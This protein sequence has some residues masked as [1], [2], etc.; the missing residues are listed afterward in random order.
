MHLSFLLIAFACSSLL[1]RRYL[2][3]S[4]RK[5]RV[6]TQLIF[7]NKPFLMLAAELH[8]SS[9]SNLDYMKPIWP[10]LAAIPLNTVFTPLSWELIEPAE[11]KF[12]LTLVD[13]LLAQAREQNLHIVFLWLARLSAKKPKPPAPAP[14][15]P[16]CVTFAHQSDPVSVSH[17]PR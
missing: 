17:L 3:P 5:T 1:G 2:R 16:S 11:G 7:D 13:G 9:S 10:R 8:N 15:P 12:D 14:S 4:S 6:A